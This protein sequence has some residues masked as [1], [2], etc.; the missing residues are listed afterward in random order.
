[1]DGRYQGA[2][3]QADPAGHQ[4]RQAGLVGGAEHLGEEGHYLLV[5]GPGVVFPTPKSACRS[6]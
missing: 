6:W 3:D 2:I 4:R 1:V 5:I